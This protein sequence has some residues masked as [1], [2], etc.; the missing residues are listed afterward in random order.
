MLTRVSGL[1][2]MGE[3]KLLPD[4]QPDNFHDDVPHGAY[5][6]EDVQTTPQPHLLT[7][8]LAEGTSHRD[9]FSGARNVKTV[10]TACF[11][12]GIA[13]ACIEALLKQGGHHAGLYKG[14][15]DTNF[16][17]TLGS[18]HVEA[19]RASLDV[20][21]WSALCTQVCPR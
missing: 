2:K 19:V 1:G 4:L 7:R 16:W 10:L 13:E 20:R 11:S 8:Q 21:S 6:N 15:D 17:S 5:D 9:V 18:L 3:G 12:W 14:L